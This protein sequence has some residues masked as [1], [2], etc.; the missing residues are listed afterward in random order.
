M[1]TR[2]LSV[3][4][5]TAEEA[6]WF[7]PMDRHAFETMLYRVHKGWFQPADVVTYSIL[8][9]L[10]AR[11]ELAYREHLCFWVSK[12][13][14]RLLTGCEDAPER[15]KRLYD[16]FRFKSE[17]HLF[18]YTGYQRIKFT[19]WATFADPDEDENNARIAE[20]FRDEIAAAVKRARDLKQRALLRGR[21]GQ[22]SRKRVR[23]G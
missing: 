20:Q 18:E 23:A 11:H 17:R 21:K 5:A 8:C 2:Y 16:G 19:D 15:V 7:A 14:L 10:R 9:Y 22:V 4:W 12:A 6:S 3:K 1:A 13:D